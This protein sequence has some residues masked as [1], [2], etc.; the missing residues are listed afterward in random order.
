[1]Q[2]NMHWVEETTEDK[3]ITKKFRI[4]HLTLCGPEI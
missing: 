4:F 2:R 1:M 3:E